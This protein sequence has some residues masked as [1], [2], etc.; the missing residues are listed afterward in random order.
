LFVYRAN[1]GAL[2]IIQNR[3]ADGARDMILGVFGGRA[4]VDDVIESMRGDIG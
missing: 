2:L 1:L 3:Q 4:H